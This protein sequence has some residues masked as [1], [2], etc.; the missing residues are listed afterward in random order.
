MF[1]DLARLEAMVTN[2]DRPV[3][4]VFAGKA[5]PADRHGQDFIKRIVELSRTPRL[6]GHIFMLE[7]YNARTARFMVQGVDVWLNN[8][9]P[10]YGSVGNL[11]DEGGHQRDSQSV[12][13][14]W[15][16]GRGLQRTQ[17]LG[18]R[19]SRGSGRL[20]RRGQ[21]RC[22]GLLQA[23]ES[24]IV[25][26]YYERDEEGLAVR[27]TEMMRESITST[28]VAFSTHRMVADYAHLAYF[29]MG[30]KATLP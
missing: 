22:R 19:F 3:Q 26:L 20:R 27:W 9:R 10:P 18:F 8:P 14:R 23:L 15:L 28:L 13:S 6:Q 17:R 25:P 29:P 12:G 7:D 5:H 4:I 24:E 16:V 11:G 21:R 2:P 1:T 30:A